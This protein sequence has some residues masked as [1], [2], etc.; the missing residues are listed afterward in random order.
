MWGA[1]GEPIFFVLALAGSVAVFFLFTAWMSFLWRHEKGRF[2]VV[3]DDA[4]A[5]KVR[6]D[7]GDFVIDR[8]NRLLRFKVAG[9]W[10]E[11][12]FE[13]IDRVD[14]GFRLARAPFRVL[15][16]FHWWDVTGEY[17][18]KMQFYRISLVTERGELPVYEV[19]Q[20]LP[21]EPFLTNAFSAQA[22]ALGR[23]GLFVDVEDR[24][25]EVLERIQTEF[26]SAGHPLTM[27][28][29]WARGGARPQG[30]A[31]S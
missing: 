12:R 9:E 24:A 21:R 13:D 30:Q 23:R 19:G 18:D 22:E 5:F 8:M 11:V 10:D 3:R 25:H 7:F 16:D 2:E 28:P 31:P 14:F 29:R 20:W 17:D 26:A 4:N 6:T 1:D 27:T 15:D